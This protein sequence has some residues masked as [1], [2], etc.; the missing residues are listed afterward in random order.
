MINLKL[1]RRAEQKLANGLLRRKTKENNN[2]IAIETLGHAALFGNV[3]AVKAAISF[4]IDLNSFTKNG[5][6]ALHKA[7]RNEQLDVVRLL[8]ESGADPNLKNKDDGEPSTMIALREG[9]K[10]IVDELFTSEIDLNARNDSGWT[11]LMTAIES[12]NIKVV[13]NLLNNKI[14]IDAQDNSGNTALSIAK[15]MQNNK[16][17]RLLLEAGAKD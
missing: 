2:S 3:N 16:I 17:T 14:E 7:I 11:L 13:K 1:R 12:E 8:L 9:N 15:E 6:T 10:F 5:E 4:G